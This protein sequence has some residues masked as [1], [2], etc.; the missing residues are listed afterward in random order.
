MQLLAAVDR[1]LAFAVTVVFLLAM[2]APCRTMAQEW[3]QK[4]V[5]V[6]VAA[7]PGGGTDV[8]SRVIF[9]RLGAMMNRTFVVENRAGASGIIGAEL[10]AKSAPD[11]Y[12]LLVAPTAA[13][14]INPFLFPN[15]TLIPERDLAG[16]SVLTRTPQVLVVP[17][18]SALH[19]VQDLINYGRA[20]PG[21]LNNSAP[22]IASVGHLAVELFKATT[23]ITSTTVPY[24]GSGPAM[25]GMLQGQ[26]DFAIDV[27]V[28]YQGK[29]KDGSLR[30]LAVA[31]A[32]RTSLFPELPTIAES[33]VPGFESSSWFALAAPARVPRELLR[34]ISTE[35]NKALET[36][37]VR[38]RLRGSGTETI[39]TT[40]E[41]T[42]RFFASEAAKFKKAVLISHMKVQ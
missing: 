26:V 17:R 9:T 12:T 32:A 14:S 38:E 5:R 8:T 34:V 10:V 7:A 18:D 1:A 22:S 13:Y 40:P 25:I 4:S 24:G 36:A 16:V 29:I 33:G 21:K 41:E 27:L 23:G 35:V 31:T 42:D 2:A 6:I 20:H 19:S 30:P 11:G 39:G 37:D 15:M 3:P 28:V